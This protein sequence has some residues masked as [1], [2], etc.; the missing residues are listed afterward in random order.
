MIQTLRV[1]F[2]SGTLVLSFRNGFKA[3]NEQQANKINYD[4]RSSEAIIF[5]A[6]SG[7]KDGVHLSSSLV[8]GTQNL[9]TKPD[10]KPVG[11]ATIGRSCW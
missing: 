6:L 9:P 8:G 4:S 3:Q 7:L 5:P 10:N 11:F 1:R 2:G